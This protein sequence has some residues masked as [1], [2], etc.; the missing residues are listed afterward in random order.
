METTISKKKSEFIPKKSKNPI[1][2]S[3]EG[4]HI[5]HSLSSSIIE[6]NIS[7]HLARKILFKEDSDYFFKSDKLY[8]K[9]SFYNLTNR[10]YTILIVGNR[11]YSFGSWSREFYFPILK[12]KGLEY[13]EYKELLQI[14]REYNFTNNARIKEAEKNI[15]T[16]NN[17][18]IMSRYFYLAVFSGIAWFFALAS[19]TNEPRFNQI[20]MIVMGSLTV[21]NVFMGLFV[22]F[23]EGTK[24][25]PP[26][27]QTFR[28]HVIFLYLE[29]IFVLAVLIV[30]VFL[31]PL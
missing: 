13:S 10:K 11:T 4:I 5:P 22:I 26:N 2:F 23:K 14:L 31:R 1:T 29:G 8:Y 18:K 9:R 27:I 16:I 30:F 12:F 7:D 24:G 21:F 20:A 25:F 6:G 19:T 3:Q 17:T 15:N 28:R